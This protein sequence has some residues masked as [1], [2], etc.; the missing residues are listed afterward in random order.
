MR[1]IQ[2]ALKLLFRN[3]GLT[4]K[5]VFKHCIVEQK[6]ILRHDGKQPAKIAKRNTRN[7]NAP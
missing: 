7:R 4:Q 6:R 3:I 1:C 5:D 2:R